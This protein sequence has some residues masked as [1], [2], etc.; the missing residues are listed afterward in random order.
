[1]PSGRNRCPI[2]LLGISL[3]SKAGQSPADVRCVCVLASCADRCM[4]HMSQL[5]Q[6]ETQGDVSDSGA[7]TTCQR[8]TTQHSLFFT[9]LIYSA[10]Q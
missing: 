4:T 2:S 7:V 10:E 9:F 5:S 3:F 6:T 1:M 8:K